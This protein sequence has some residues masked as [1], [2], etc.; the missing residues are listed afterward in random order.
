MATHPFAVGEIVK[1]KDKT[2]MIT[3]IS[4]QLGFNRFSITD[5][6]TGHT[7]RAFGYELSRCAEI[8]AALLPEMF[9]GQMVEEEAATPDAEA[10]M[11]VERGPRWAMLSEAEL[12]EIAEN[13]HSKHTATQT[14]WAAK[15]FRGMIRHCVATVNGSGWSV[16]LTKFVKYLSILKNCTYC[17]LHVA[18]RCLCL[19]RIS[20]FYSSFR[21]GRCLHASFDYAIST[22]IIR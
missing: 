3:S 18:S 22:Y 1:C 21:R 4:H 12:D 20:H 13:R 17:D 8:T 7:F 16:N 19:A 14:K 15:V 5:I 10:D 2:C 6:D 9:E 11:S